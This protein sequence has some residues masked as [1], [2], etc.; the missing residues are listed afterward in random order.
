MRSAGTT[1]YTASWRRSAR[2]RIAWTSPPAGSC[3]GW[4]GSATAHLLA[5]E[6]VGDGVPA[7]LAA[8]LDAGDEPAVVGDAPVESGRAQGDRWRRR[9]HQGRCRF[10]LG[11]LGWLGS[12]EASASQR[13]SAEA[14][15][16]P[17]PA[18]LR[19]RVED[20]AVAIP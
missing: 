11:W 12:P 6:V 17:H 9:Q 8:Q 14:H 3:H 5:G 16:H 10:G 13:P 4:L 20:A 19:E 15:L 18:E 2:S 1:L 7:A